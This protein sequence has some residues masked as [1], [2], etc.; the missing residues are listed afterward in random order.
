MDMDFFKASDGYRESISK[1]I[2]AMQ[3]FKGRAMYGKGNREEQLQRLKD[4]IR[5]CDAVLIGAGAGL[6]T[7]AGL[8]YSGERFEK[9][10]FDFSKAFG[11]KDMYSGGFYPFPKKYFGHGGRDIFILTDILMLQSLY[12][13]ICWNW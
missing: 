5:S 9:Y 7:S 3:Y 2:A 4:E 1:G 8:T 13:K 10:F 6:S 12:I 11:I